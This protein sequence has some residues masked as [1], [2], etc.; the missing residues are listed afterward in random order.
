M[1]ST[2]GRTINIEAH[3]STHIFKRHA[4]AAALLKLIYIL[5]AHS[6]VLLYE[7]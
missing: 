4:A 7:T 3:V 5:H 2:H 6:F 1:S